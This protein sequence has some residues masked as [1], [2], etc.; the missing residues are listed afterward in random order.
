MLPAY[1]AYLR[2]GVRDADRRTVAHGLPVPPAKLRI[3]VSGTPD[4]DFFL[5]TGRSQADFFRSMLERNGQPVETLDAVLDFGCGCGRIARWWTDLERPAIFG[6]D[7]NPELVRWTRANLPFV[8]TAKS[9]SDPPLPY[10]DDSFDFVYALSIFTHLPERQALAW[11]AELHRVIRPGG[12]LLFT[13]AGEAYVDRLSDEERSRYDRGQEVVQFE[14]ARGTN[15]CIA[16]HPPGY[17]RARML[18]RFDLLE[19]F[20][21]PAHPEEAE[22]SRMPQ[23]SYLACV[24]V[25]PSGGTT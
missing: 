3:L 2:L 17:V 14:T 20:L 13:I 25:E 11:M 5:T 12:R 22:R 21:T 1:Q 16:Y 10:P 4:L 18:G 8:N 6:C 23:D 15:L 7:P 24:P 19:E 9:E